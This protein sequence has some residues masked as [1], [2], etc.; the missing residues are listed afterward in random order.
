MTK[1]VS[2][3]CFAAWALVENA[4]L[5]AQVPTVWK[6]GATKNTP[7][8]AY[9]IHN[10]T[11]KIQIQAPDGET[12]TTPKRFKLPL[13]RSWAWLPIGAKIQ[14]NNLGAKNNLEDG[15]KVKVKMVGTN[16]APSNPPDAPDP[17]VDKNELQKMLNNFQQQLTGAEQR[18]RSLSADFWNNK[19]KSSSNIAFWRKLDEKETRL[20]RLMAEATQAQ[21]GRTPV[22]EDKIFEIANL[23]TEKLNLEKEIPESEKKYLA[24]YQ[25]VQQGRME[26]YSIEEQIKVLQK[27]LAQ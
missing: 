20:Q 9:L 24:D 14:Q 26:V 11:T 16:T 27:M 5:S 7:Q 25:R 4:P 13:L 10:P 17:A 12:I 21:N 18:E 23:T 19:L 6:L 8:G 15:K 1:L 2:I 3:V 22:S